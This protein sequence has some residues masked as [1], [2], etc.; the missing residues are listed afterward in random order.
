MQSLAI[1]LAA[2]LT[3]SFGTPTLHPDSNVQVR[4]M[5][6]TSESTAIGRTQ[7]LR[8]GDIARL[9]G[10]T[11]RAI[12]LYEELGLLKPATRSAGGYRLFDE[13]AV[14]RV[15]WIDSLHGLGFSLQEMREV[16]EN[17]WTAEE[18]PA[19]MGELRVLFQ[20]KLEQTRDAIRRHRQLETELEEG[21]R[22]LETCENCA[23]PGPVGACVNC[24]QD[25]GVAVAPALVAGIQGAPDSAPKATRPAFVRVEDMLDTSIPAAGKAGGDDSG[26]E[27]AK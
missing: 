10:K 16:L 27:H 20:R 7:L 12:H 24:R 1:A 18:G 6:T 15:R 22:Y 21:L 8:V 13:S 9:S 2:P 17:W 5:S 26:K 4:V 3:Q 14:E 23:A 25:H 19:A 11:V